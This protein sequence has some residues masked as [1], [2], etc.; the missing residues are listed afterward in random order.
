MNLIDELRNPLELLYAD[1][2][3]EY[4][5]ANP[6]VFDELFDFMFVDDKSIAW[7]AGWVCDKISRKNPSW[8]SDNHINKIFKKLPFE[9]HKGTLRSF[10]SIINNLYNGYPLSVE[11]INFL[12]DLMVSTRSDVSHQ[13]LS[14]KILAQYS[15]IE[16]DLGVE[17]IAYLSFLS[18]ED[19]TPGFNSVR[20]KIL[21]QLSKK[22]L[23]KDEF[24]LP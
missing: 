23:G 9:K 11:I 18:P 19:Y 1:K 7:R 21:K 6:H 22:Q 13:V 5:Y 15:E 3:A 12:F 8:F 10:L 16:P 17:L 20:K 14:M 24:S 4:V 2:L